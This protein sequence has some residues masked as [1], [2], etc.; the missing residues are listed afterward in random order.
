MTTNQPVSARRRFWKTVLLFGA[1]HFLVMSLGILVESGSGGCMF[2][3]PAYFMILPV[4]LSILILRRLG[5]GTAVFLPYAIL[6]IF[7]VYYFELP[8]MYGLWGVAAW[9]LIGPLVGLVADLTFK[10]LPE[11]IPERW[12]AILLGAVT[13]AALFV[14]T[15]VALA[16]FYR[17][18]ELGL[19][20]RYF[21]TGIYF[22]LPWLVVNGGF[23]GYTAYALTK[24]V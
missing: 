19:H 16:T 23:A 21:T 4:M 17:E 10:F 2:I 1:I 22:S 15:Y 14:T 7:P 9:C 18:P 6:G 24:R 12:R 5:A 20:F 13:G 11:R 3:I 8:K